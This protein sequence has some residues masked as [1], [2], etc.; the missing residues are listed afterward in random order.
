MTRSDKAKRVFE[1]LTSKVMYCPDCI[2]GLNDFYSGKKL[3]GKDTPHVRV[4][5]STKV[6]HMRSLYW[7]WWRCL[8]C[9]RKAV[10]YSSE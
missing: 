2:S 6:D 3:T 1:G 7:A 5:E 9:D 4:S 8:L 10:R